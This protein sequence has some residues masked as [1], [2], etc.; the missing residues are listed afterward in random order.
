MPS[1]KKLDTSSQCR[2]GGASQS[3]WSNGG[4]MRPQIGEVGPAVVFNAAFEGDRSVGSA[5]DQR[6]LSLLIPE[7]WDA[8]PVRLR[9]H[10]HTLLLDEPRPLLASSGARRPGCRVQKPTE[11][12]PRCRRSATDCARKRPKPTS[13]RAMYLCCDGP[14]IANNQVELV[15]AN[16]RRAQNYAK[17]LFQCFNDTF[18]RRSAVERSVCSA[19]SSSQQ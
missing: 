1:A 10:I 11:N 9:L 19:A 13:C 16:G 6:R 4:A 18:L 5:F 7:K 14:K 12:R 3:C 17:P 2:S 8:P 15:V